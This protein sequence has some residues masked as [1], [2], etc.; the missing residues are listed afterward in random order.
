MTRIKGAG[1][2]GEEWKEEAHHMPFQIL[3]ADVFHH[4]A[5]HLT[6]IKQLWHKQAASD[7]PKKAASVPNL[8]STGLTPRPLSI[9]FALQS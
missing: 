7:M 8:S 4:L 2:A 6:I 9:H 1:V 3:L 5:H